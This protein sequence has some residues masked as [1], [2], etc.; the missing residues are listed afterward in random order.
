MQTDGIQED[1]PV[2]HIPAL[3]LAALCLL[4]FMNIWFIGNY[5]FQG[6]GTTDLVLDSNIEYIMESYSIETEGTS[7]Y[8]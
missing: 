4:L 7:I 5:A 3:R 2:F 1:V 8:N 6:R